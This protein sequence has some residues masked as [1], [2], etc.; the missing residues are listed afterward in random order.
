MDLK[1]II[2]PVL[3]AVIF[4]FAKIENKKTEKN[5]DENNF[6]VRQSITFLLI[7]IIAFISFSAL[8]IYFFIYP[9]DSMEWWVYLLFIILVIPPLLLLIYCLKWKLIINGNQILIK[10]FIGK[11]K[12]ITIDQI[13]KIKLKEGQY[14]TAFI[15]K[16]KL[17][18]VYPTCI[19]YNVLVSRLKKEIKNIEY[20]IDELKLT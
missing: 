9:D 15:G 19:G 3:V 8:T 6:K 1:Y 20:N 5:M 2:T 16:K 10:P 14:L 13:T 18:S 17:F 11:K 7:S 12:I 4:V